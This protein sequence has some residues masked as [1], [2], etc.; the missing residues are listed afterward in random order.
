MLV[1]VSSDSGCHLGCRGACLLS[2]SKHV[3]VED[4]SELGL[5]LD[6]LMK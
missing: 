2:L 3:D 6:R 4:T 5:Q 1:S